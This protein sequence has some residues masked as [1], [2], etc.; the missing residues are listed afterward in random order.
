MEIR[1]SSGPRDGHSVMWQLLS[2]VPDV[3]G[4]CVVSQECAQSKGPVVVPSALCLAAGATGKGQRLQAPMCLQKDKD[5]DHLMAIVPS[6][7][8]FPVEGVAVA[9][10]AEK[11]Q[12]PGLCR[13]HF[14]K[15]YSCPV[16]FLLATGT[17]VWCK[18]W[19]QKPVGGSPS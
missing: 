8:K 11:K 12:C 18:L 15:C 9:V 10:P 7:A 14:P 4:I 17:R 2:Y 13:S 5:N 16:S 19:G 1:F 3:S 6:G